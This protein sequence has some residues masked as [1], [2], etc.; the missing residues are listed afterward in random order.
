MDSVSIVIP[1]NRPYAVLAPCLASIAA[2]R[3]DAAR[4]EVIVA[5]NGVDAPRSRVV[6]WPFRLRTAQLPQPNIAAAKNAA[7]EL[8]RNPLLIFINDD[9][10][11][12][13]DFV[14][15]HLAAH[16]T[17]AAAAMVLGRA[18]WRVFPDE[19]AFDLMIRRTPMIFRYERLRPDAWHDFRCAWNLNLS[20]PRRALGAER[21]D[22]GLGPFFYEDLELAHRLQQRDGLRVWYAPRARCLHDHRYT[23]E[24]YLE[25]E[26]AQGA[27]AV[28]LWRCRP[29]CFRAIF[30][31]GL[32]AAYLDYCRAYL[33]HESPRESELRDL[34]ERVAPLPATALASDPQVR[35]EMVRALYHAHL[36]LKRLVFRRALLGAAEI[37]PS[38]GRPGADRA[39]QELASGGRAGP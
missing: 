32:D 35:E 23:L 2:Q 22:A 29:E 11:L 14:A 8:A 3:F 10:R 17:L 16:E 33:R 27:A 5:F 19:T 1:T 21:F 31:T 38:A 26:R 6:E 39:G 9:V 25:R 13:P 4:I 15:Q 24:G 12:D 37:A 18:E 20:I 7:L 36:P 28:R 30:S 34:L